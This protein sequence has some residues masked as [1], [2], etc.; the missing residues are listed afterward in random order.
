MP[1]RFTMGNTCLGW[2]RILKLFWERGEEEEV[3]KTKKVHLL[4][5]KGYLS[6]KG[7]RGHTTFNVDYVTYTKEHFIVLQQSVPVAP[8]V[9]MHVQM[10]Q[11]SNPKKSE[12][13]IAREHRNNFGS[14]L[15]LQI[16]DQDAGVQL[17]DTNPDDIEIL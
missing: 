4:D 8:Y 7:T 16:I 5:H 3:K 13:W 11:S 10:L 17:V 2:T 14:W 9:K 12:D 1:Q 15:R 6:G